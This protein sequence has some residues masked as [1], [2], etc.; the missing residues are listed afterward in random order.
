MSRQLKAHDGLAYLLGRVAGA[1]E[2]LNQLEQREA[3]KFLE[4]SASGS[5]STLAEHGR[6]GAFRIES[7]NPR[8]AGHTTGAGK[9]RKPLNA[10]DKNTK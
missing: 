7:Q 10:V 3:E 5:F 4:E 8:A 9:K 1:A 2:R 6:K